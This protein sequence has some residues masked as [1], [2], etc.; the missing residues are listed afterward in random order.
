MQK[1]ALLLMRYYH[2]LIQVAAFYPKKLYKFKN[3]KIQST[4]LILEELIL[5]YLKAAD[6]TFF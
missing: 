5:E 4:N 2:F 6:L 1:N 3:T